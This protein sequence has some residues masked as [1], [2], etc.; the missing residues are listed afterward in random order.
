MSKIETLVESFHGSLIKTKEE[1]CGDI[2]R[3]HINETS[4]V[5]VLADGLGSGVKAN[6]LATLTATILS[7]MLNQGLGLDDAVETITRTLPECAERKIAYSTF[8]VLQVFSDG[9][10]YLAEFDQ[11]QSIVLRN[12]EEVAILRT[13]IRL[14]NRTIYESHFTVLP[15]DVIVLYSDGVLHAGI[16][17][18]LNFG[19]ARS[20]VVNHLKQTIRPGDSAMM[21]T[22]TLLAAVN[23][24]YQGCAGDDATVATAK[25]VRGNQTTV[26][27][28]PPS[29]K[30]LD[31]E[32]VNQLMNSDG[33]KIVC[34][35]TTAQLVARE[36]N[37]PI[38]VNRILAIRQEVPPTASIQGIDLVTEGV[39]TLAKTR[40][41][42]RQCVKSEKILRNLLEDQSEDGA[43]LLA[44]ALLFNTIKIRFIVGQADNPA[45]RDMSGLLISLNAKLSIIHEIAEELKSMKKI[46][47]IELH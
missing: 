28:G 24:L 44:K 22:D 16:G 6:I 40:D 5:M 25:I 20:E 11:P 13:S 2:V 45:H 23:D 4:F 18:V 15:D 31:V 38:N 35:G 42:L 33:L 37:V 17:R 34:G 1:L 27:V 19:W 29:D 47:T 26:M 10:A 41:I 14:Q 39:L 46:V 3:D 30:K 9:N 7:E 32:I 36:L 12:L 21:I 43:T 8:A